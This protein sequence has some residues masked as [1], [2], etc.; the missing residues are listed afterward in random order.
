MLLGAAGAVAGQALAEL[1]HVALRIAEVAPVPAGSGAALDL[2][3]RL[4]A[5]LDQP[6][7]GGVDVAHGEAGLEPGAVVLRLIAPAEQLE[8][9]RP[10]HVELDPILAGV[11]LGERQDLTVEPALSLE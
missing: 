2:G 4:R 3:D 1:E 6:R 11:D 8:K 5:V 10:A 9:V 7:A